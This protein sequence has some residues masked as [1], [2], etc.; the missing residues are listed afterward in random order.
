MPYNVLSKNSYNTVFILSPYSKQIH[1]TNSIIWFTFS[2]YSC[3]HRNKKTIDQ[4][5]LQMILI[6]FSKKKKKLDKIT[7]NFQI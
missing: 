4:F 1:I 6:F 5:I 2:K 3:P 7:Y